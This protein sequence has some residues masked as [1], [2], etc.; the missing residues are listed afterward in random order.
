MERLSLQLLLKQTVMTDGFVAR[1][2]HQ[3]LYSALSNTGQSPESGVFYGSA[4]QSA[5][6][7][8]GV[9]VNEP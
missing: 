6:L 3:P 1:S 9:T 2:V 4:P 7:D 5:K 8:D